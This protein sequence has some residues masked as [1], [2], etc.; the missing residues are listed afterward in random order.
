M[1]IG[2]VDVRLGYY[3][4]VRPTDLRIWRRLK[5]D[6]MNIG[7]DALEVEL[8]ILEN[9]VD[10]YGHDIGGVGLRKDGSLRVKP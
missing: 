2:D 6:E 8:V 7:N 10:I 4:P 3:H 1:L 9:R 5:R